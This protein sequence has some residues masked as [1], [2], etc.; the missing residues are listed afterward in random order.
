MQIDLHIAKK[1]VIHIVLLIIQN[2]PC[3]IC[4]EHA[5]QYIKNIIL[6]IVIAEMN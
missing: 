1:D 2:I 6:K 4:R 3:P 5:E